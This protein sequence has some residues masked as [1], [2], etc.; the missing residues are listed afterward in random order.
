MW[1]Y[2]FP[3]GTVSTRLSNSQPDLSGMVY[4]GDANPVEPKQQFD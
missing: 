1:V 3:V 2:C 4:V